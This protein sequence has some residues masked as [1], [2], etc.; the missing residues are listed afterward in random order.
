MHFEL[1]DSEKF[2]SLVNEIA[3]LKNLVLSMIETKG[4]P[5][6]YF[7]NAD[8]YIFLE[9]AL[10]KH[11]VSRSTIQKKVHKYQIPTFRIGKRLKIEEF[12]L[13]ASLKK[14]EPKPKFKN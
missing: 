11:K 1:I 6:P 4:K 5:E 14:G 12:Q 13:I 3:E 2:N 8:G 9:D 7:T 10:I